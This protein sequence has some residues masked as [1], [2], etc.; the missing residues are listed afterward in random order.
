MRNGTIDHRNF[1]KRFLRIV[2]SLGDGLCYFTG[3]AQAKGYRGETNTVMKV[4]SRV[5]LDR[6][7]VENWSLLFDLKIIMM[8]VSS[9]IKGDENAY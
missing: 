1:H 6:F 5:K 9:M 8:T 7:Y 3:L 2:H 4:K